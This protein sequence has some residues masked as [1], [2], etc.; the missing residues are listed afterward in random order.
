[1]SL[2][3]VASQEKDNEPASY[4]NVAKEQI[5]VWDPDIIFID[6]S[7]LRLGVDIN[8]LEQLR[9]D[10]SYKHL[11]AVKNNQVYGLFPNYSYNQNI[12]VVLANA[13]FIGKVI[14]PDSFS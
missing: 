6:I 12:E 2:K 3:N 10:P 13:Y 1:M 11:H 7:T 9:N 14:Y 4:L 8:A 5:I